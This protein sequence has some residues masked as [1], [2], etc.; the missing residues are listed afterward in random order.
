MYTIAIKVKV[1]LYKLQEFLQILSSLQGNAAS[2]GGAS[3]LKLVEDGEDQTCFSLIY[4]W[5]AEEDLTQYL[6]GEEFKVLL[7]ALQI[8]CEESVVQ[9]KLIPEHLIHYLAPM[10]NSAD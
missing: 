2:E 4:R 6:R 7:G 10:F 8:L 5:E 1:C 9:H 3:N